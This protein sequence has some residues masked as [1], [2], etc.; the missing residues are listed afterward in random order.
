MPPVAV[1]TSVTVSVSP[2]TSV[3]LSRS[4]AVT[5]VA[6][7]S[8]AVAV[9]SSAT[10]ASLTQVEVDGDR[11]RV[12]AAV[13]VVDRVVEEAD[14]VAAQV[15]V[16]MNVIVPPSSDDGAARGV[17]DGRDGERV[18]VDVAVVVGQVGGRDHEVVSSVPEASSSAA[19]GSSFAQVMSTVT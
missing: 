12:G 17:R 2:S 16:G 10:G 5:S 9:S 1:E 13:A 8:L 15:G 4:R 3:S 14:V 7:S 11:A 6:V 19:M 18:A